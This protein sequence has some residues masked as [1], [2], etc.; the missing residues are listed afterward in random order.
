[1]VIDGREVH[2]TTVSTAVPGPLVRLQEGED[3]VLSVTNL[4]SEDSSI[5]C[6]RPV[7]PWHTTLE[8]SQG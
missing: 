2:A 5:H 6:S 7:S 8:R 3:A 1:V 4:L